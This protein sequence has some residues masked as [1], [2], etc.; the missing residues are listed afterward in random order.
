[1]SAAFS[2]ASGSIFVSPARLQLHINQ[3][4][5]EVFHGYETFVKGPGA[6]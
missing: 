5:R 3:R 2:N 6:V 4:R 1:V